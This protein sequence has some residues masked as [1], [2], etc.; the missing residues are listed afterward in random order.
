MEKKIKSQTHAHTQARYVQADLL[1]ILSETY[2]NQTSLSAACLAL[3]VR[4]CVR[5]FVCSVCVCGV[6]DAH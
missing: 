2:E 6:H 4:R 5:V 1:S 3:E